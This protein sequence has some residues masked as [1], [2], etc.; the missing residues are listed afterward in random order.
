MNGVIAAPNSTRVQ[1]RV[2]EIKAHEDG[3]FDCVISIEKFEPLYG[4]CFLTL[5]EKIT[6]F[7]YQSL[8][9]IA[10]GQALELEVEYIGGPHKGTYQIKHISKLDE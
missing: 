10:P 8:Q 1:A 2:V 6:A 7:T 3:K 5:G 9:D 4:P